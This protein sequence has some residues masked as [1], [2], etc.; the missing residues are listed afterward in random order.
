MISEGLIDFAK[1]V[2]EPQILRPTCWPPNTVSNRIEKKNSHKQ[3]QKKPTAERNY[4]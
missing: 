3:K 1:T 2:D 4:L